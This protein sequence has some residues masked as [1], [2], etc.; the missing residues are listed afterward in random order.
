MIFVLILIQPLAG[1]AESPSVATETSNEA[2]IEVLSNDLEGL[3]KNIIKE[4]LQMEKEDGQITKV[5]DEINQSVVAIIGNNKTYRQQDHVYTK[6]PSNLQHGSGVIISSDGK[7]ITNNHVV[8]DM[9][10]IY[11]VMYDGKAYQA[12]LLYRDEEID[13]ALIKI[14]RSNVKPVKLEAPDNVKVGNTVIAIGT[15]LYFGYRNSAS[16]GIISGL[17]RPVD[18]T[19]TYLQTDASVNPGNSGGPLVNMDGKLVGINTLGYVYYSGMNFAIPVEN[20][21]YFLDHYHQFGRIRRCYTGIQ[22]EENWAAML[23][24]PTNQGLRVVTLRQDAVVASSQVQEGDMLEA[25]DGIKTSSIAAYNEALKQ[26]L[27]GNQVTLTFSRNNKPFD[28]NVTL[29]DRP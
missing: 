25:I 21:S 27:P 3:I 9:E 28:I 17:N 12:Q 2:S 22:F 19:Y 6:M 1:F 10:E 20:V 14:N 13:L 29:K 7:I 23:G 15:P 8:K 11:V 4:M 18:E 26:Y 16:R 5:I 24:I